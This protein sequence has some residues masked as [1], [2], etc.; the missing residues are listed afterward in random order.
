MAMDLETAKMVLETVVVLGAVGAG[1]W[2]TSRI[3]GRVADRV[4]S[5]PGLSDRVDTLT[6]T[7]SDIRHEM[8]PNGGG[9][10]R[11][12]INRI[13]ATGRQTAERLDRHIERT[14][15]GSDG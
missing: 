1:A 14:A 4:S 6:E 5:I 2:R 3:L 8:S 13:E 11:D 10:M 9:S 15:G 12:A 7:I